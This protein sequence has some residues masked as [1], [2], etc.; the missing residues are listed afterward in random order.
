MSG[1]LERTSWLASSHPPPS[2]RAHLHRFFYEIS[3]GW[4]RC[5]TASQEQHTLVI[6]LTVQLT[7]CLAANLGSKWSEAIA[8]GCIAP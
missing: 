2:S 3:H 7:S 6:S 8:L 1:F 5:P 4:Q